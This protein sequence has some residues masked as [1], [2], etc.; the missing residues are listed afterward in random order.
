MSDDILL[1]IAPPEAPPPGTKPAH[2]NEQGEV[3]FLN[4]KTGAEEWVPEPQAAAAAQAGLQPLTLEELSKIQYQKRLDS[5][6]EAGLE[7]A[8]SAF[9]LG[10][11]ELLARLRGDGA[12][13]GFRKDLKEANPSASMTGDIVGSVASSLAGPLGG[14][15]SLGGKAAAKI[16]GKMLPKAAPAIGSAMTEGAAMTAASEI[17][18]QNLEQRFDPKKIAQ[19][20][21]IGSAL[22]GSLS[23]AGMGLAKVGGK[24]KNKIFNSSGVDEKTLNAWVGEKRALQGE[25]KNFKIQKIPDDLNDLLKQ[26][27]ALQ[28]QIKKEAVALNDVVIKDGLFKEAKLTSLREKFDDASNM[29]RASGADPRL[30]SQGVAYLL[31]VE[32]ESATAL[33]AA[34]QHLKRGWRTIENEERVARLKYVRTLENDL[35]QIHIKLDELR[36]TPENKKAILNALSQRDAIREQSQKLHIETARSTK[37]VN[38]ELIVD[39]LESQ[40]NNI[41]NQIRVRAG[42]LGLDDFDLEKYYRYSDRLSDLSQKVSKSRQAIFETAARPLAFL[43]RNPMHGA[44]MTA[45]AMLLGTVGVSVREI[46]TNTAVATAKVYKTAAKSFP[47]MGS[48]GKISSIKI[49]TD[50]E[51]E[52]AQ[53][54]AQEQDP[55]IIGQDAMV[56]YSNAG[57]DEQFSTEMAEF[58][59]KRLGAIQEVLV[60]DDK[61]KASKTI[62]ALEDP[63]RI[64]MRIRRGEA[65][66][67]DIQVLKQLFPQA[68]Q[69][70]AMTAQ[71]L[72][73]DKNLSPERR[74]Q[75]NLI[76]EPD[77]FSR[78]SQIIKQVFQQSEE[79]PDPRGRTYDMQTNMQRIARG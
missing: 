22:S 4:P 57:L 13:L 36:I 37:R 78:V 15:G 5:P 50:R 67:E 40:I 11:P 8:V 21:I 51:F 44:K 46:L 29:V 27:S 39:D 26:K 34:Q 20:A 70:L 61:I 35:K 79:S 10:T 12:Y 63:R 41:T 30:N 32:K 18:T 2:M 71:Q 33:K 25:F 69:E 65:T 14:L 47:L 17:V 56:G 62:N 68:Y 75:L 77:G 23:L 53:E 54:S 55:M 52:E 38:Q 16:A 48:V 24:I 74:Q 45:G 9:T 3:A 19:Q 64:T 28:G 66:R 60:S 1:G 49:L 73:K 6:M 43:R 58:E 31:D 7:S 76:I 72:L 42:R 59:S